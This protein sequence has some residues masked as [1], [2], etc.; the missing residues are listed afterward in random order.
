[1]CSRFEISSSAREIMQALSLK[2]PPPLPNKPEVRP[3]DAALM[4]LDDAGERRSELRPWGLRVDWSTQ[5]MINARA[6]TLNEK[7]TFRPLLESR[8]VLPASAYFEWRK[9]ET[10]EK[11]KNRIYGDDLLVMAG[12]YDA[13]RVTIVTCPPAPAIQ[14]IH[15]RMPVLLDQNGIQAWLSNAP[16]RDVAP[17]LAPFAGV[18]MF[19]EET[20]PPPAQQDLFG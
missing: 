7:P 10:A 9:T 6:E 8:C 1:M 16:S 18:L 11:R 19:D 2:A 3:T 20:P 12:L 15:N 13:E 4:I 17:V 5:P 14:H